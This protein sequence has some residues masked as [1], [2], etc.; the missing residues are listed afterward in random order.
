MQKLFQAISPIF[1]WSTM[2]VTIGLAIFLVSISR[3]ILLIKSVAAAEAT[4]VVVVS[5]TPALTESETMAADGLVNCDCE[6]TFA[7]PASVSWE[8]KV[9]AVF[10]SGAGLGV[11]KDDEKNGV[12]QFFVH[13]PEEDIQD[14]GDTVKVS[15]RLVGVTCAYANTVFGE[16]VS[17]VEAETVVPVILN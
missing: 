11:E 8:G 13:V 14:F 9:I 6:K 7:N 4:S 1:F 17:E 5:R 3:E 2:T 16:C 10:M 15:G 12:N